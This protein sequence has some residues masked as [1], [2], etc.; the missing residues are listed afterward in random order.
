MANL[1]RK[2]KE[3][4]DE[5]FGVIDTLFCKNVNLSFGEDLQLAFRAAA[6]IIVCALPFLAPREFCPICYEVVRTKFYNSASVVYFVF[7]LYKTTGDTIYF[8]CGGLTGTVIAVLNI[9]LMMGFFP[10]GY[11]PGTPNADMVFW[12]GNV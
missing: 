8:A 9:W 7:T 2:K 10:G 11:Q 1:A 4:E 3:D 12:A 6:F 5:E